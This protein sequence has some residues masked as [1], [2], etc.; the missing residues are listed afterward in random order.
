MGGC[1][2]M[3]VVLRPPWLMVHLVDCLAG[4]VLVVMVVVVGWVGCLAV[5]VVL[6]PEQQQQGLVRVESWQTEL[7]ELLVL[8]VKA[9]LLLLP[10]SHSSS[11]C[12][13]G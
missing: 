1:L 6:V 8:G 12:Q 7:E 11:S 9:G 4:V 3:V 2:A 5:V 10:V 13:R